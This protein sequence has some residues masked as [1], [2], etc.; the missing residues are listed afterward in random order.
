VL[1]AKLDQNQSQ[2]GNDG[3][4]STVTVE[5]IERRAYEIYL[6]RGGEF[7]RDVEDWLQAELKLGSLKA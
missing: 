6:G 4:S 2:P 3:D 1:E 7:G 5:D